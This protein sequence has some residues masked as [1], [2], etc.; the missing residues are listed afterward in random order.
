MID[1][2]VVLVLQAET[3]LTPLRVGKYSLDERM[4]DSVCLNING[5][6]YD[7]DQSVAAATLLKKARS[8]SSTQAASANVLSSHT[9]QKSSLY[10]ATQPAYYSAGAQRKESAAYSSHSAG[11]ASLHQGASWSQSRQDWQTD[12]RTHQPTNAAYT[13]SQSASDAARQYA[14]TPTAVYSQYPSSS[15]ASGNSGTYKSSTPGR[16]V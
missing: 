7:F 14:S 12:R 15:S 1:N 5:Q 4:F 16:I 13:A 9:S 8:N 6:A 10:Q 11:S 3:A 2:K